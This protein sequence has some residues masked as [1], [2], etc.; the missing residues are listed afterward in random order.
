MLRDTS[1]QQHDS[2]KVV[3]RK[4]TYVCLACES[5]FED[6]CLI[7]H[8]CHACD[9]VVP[10]TE[11]E[12]EGLEDDRSHRRRAKK[13]TDIRTKLPP[14]LSTGRKAWDI[15]LGGGVS[16]PSSVLVA[17]PSGTGK[18]TALLAIL[19][20]LGERLQRPV[21]Y[22]CAEMPEE[23]LKQFCERLG[24]KMKHLYV[25][26]SKQAE[27]MHDDILELSPCAIVWDS[28]QRFRVNGSL[29]EVELR[30]VVTGAIE[31]GDRVKAATFLIS[32]VTKEENF[33]GPNGIGHDVDVIIHLK[34]AGENLVSVE[35]REKNRFAPTPMTATEPLY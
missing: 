1:C 16:R 15:V 14:V 35:T 19:D 13:A 11:D 20:T 31:S 28:I 21:L 29:G 2:K 10:I 5:L 25:N 9:T 12:I 18:T 24:L 33:M 27:D 26:T 6:F 30:D 22:G 4:D 34:K 32:H 3:K 8:H 7:C 23:L 17:G